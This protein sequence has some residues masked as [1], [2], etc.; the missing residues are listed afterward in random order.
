MNNDLTNYYCI[1]RKKQLFTECIFLLFSP[2]SLQ[3]SYAFS[4]T[5]K[6]ESIILWALNQF[7]L[8]FL[9]FW[10]ESQ[11]SNLETVAANQIMT[12]R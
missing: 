2:L 6:D 9:G 8:I 3:W 7:G 4:F 12:E 1:W 10:E 5:G 11:K